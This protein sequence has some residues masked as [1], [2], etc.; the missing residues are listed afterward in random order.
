[1]RDIL[2][3]VQGNSDYVKPKIYDKDNVCSQ[4]IQSNLRKKYMT[5]QEYYN[6]KLTSD[7]MYNEPRHIVSIFKDYLIFDDFSEYLKR[8]Y[9]FHESAE[10]LP[11]IFQFYTKYSKVYPNYV[12]IPQES[13]FMFKNIERKQKLIDQRNKRIQEF[14]DNKKSG[15]KTKQTAENSNIFTQQFRKELTKY[16][17]E[18]SKKE[19]SVFNE[20]FSHLLG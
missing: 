19:E 18:P 11:R 2:S 6:S 16:I 20:K 4:V 15:K 7:I 17:M 12:A 14:K 1:M 3:G 10:R 8:G 9:R 5:S 13:R